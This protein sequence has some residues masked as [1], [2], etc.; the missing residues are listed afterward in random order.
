MKG[1]NS[2]LA[3]GSLIGTIIGAGVFGIPYIVAKSGVLTSLFYFLILGSLVLLLHLFFGEI[4]LRTGEKHRLVGYAQYYLGKKAKIL[5][6]ISVIFGTIGALLAYVILGGEFLKIIFPYP[7][8]VVQFSLILWAIL[9]LFVFWGIKS[10]A[11]FELLMNIGLFGAFFLIFLFCFPKIEPSNFVLAD[12]NYLFLP[13]GIF[14]FSLI[15]WNAVPEVERI[16]IKKKNLKK[17]IFWA[18]IISTVFYFLFGL[19]I[20]GVTGLQTT[21]EPFLGL[22]PF[23]GRKIIIL[24]GIFGLFAVSTSFLILANYLKNTFFLDYRLP[25][26]LSFFLATFLPL[27]LFLA[28]IREFIIVIAFVGTFVGLIEGIVISLIY[29]RAKKIGK[30]IPEYSLK[31]PNFLIYLTIIILIFGTLSQIIYY[32]R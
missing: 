16:L 8:S 22:L 17:V 13:F 24:G 6:T 32:F 20:S 18:I 23:L 19:V 12:K 27:S 5:V 3:A 31:I 1:K 7:L 10:I 15:G 29:R 26:F 28:G 14:L 21:K 30:R 2:L 25:Y 11:P 4:V 9:S